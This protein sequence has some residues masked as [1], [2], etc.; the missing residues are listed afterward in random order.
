MAHG[1]A[2]CCGSS[3]FLKSIFGVGYTMTIVKKPGEGVVASQPIIDLVYKHV[4]PQSRGGLNSLKLSNGNHQKD[5]NH[6]STH[7][8]QNDTT[9]S[10][11]LLSTTAAEE[12]IVGIDHSASI[13]TGAVAFGASNSLDV[14]EN[15]INGVNTMQFSAKDET[16]VLS[17]AGGEISFRVPFSAAPTFPRL[18]ND[19]DNADICQSVGIEHYGVSVTTLEEVFLRVGQDEEIDVKERELNRRR[20]VKSYDN[21]DDDDGHRKSPYLR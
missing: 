4:Q 5:K 11:R 19:L 15:R 3:L 17:D 12:N 1:E 13:S 16:T 2:R 10:D 9:T 14:C 7:N 6:N 20:S 8:N 18:F 21:D